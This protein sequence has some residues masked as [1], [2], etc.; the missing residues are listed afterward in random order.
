MLRLVALGESAIEGERCILLVVMTIGNVPLEFSAVSVSIYASGSSS[1]EG[2]DGP[3]L[4]D[5]LEL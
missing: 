3:F 4:G 1:G 2:I 5:L